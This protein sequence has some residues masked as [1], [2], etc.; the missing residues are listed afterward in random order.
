[1][2]TVDVITTGVPEILLL[3]TEGGVGGRTY[4]PRAK[5]TFFNA[6]T[7]PALGAGDV[8]VVQ[9]NGSL[10]AGFAYQLLDLRVTLTGTTISQLDNFADYCRYQ[11]VLD[12][13]VRK[14]GVLCGLGSYSDGAKAF[15][16]FSPTTQDDMSQY[17][18]YP[19]DKIGDQVLLGGQDGDVVLSV[20]L[21]DDNPTTTACTIF[22]EFDF[23]Q[24]TIEQARKA[25]IYAKLFS[26]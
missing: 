4:L 7:I 11:F 15:E 26:R 13:L 20:T 16:A 22:Y 17:M 2:A 12:G 23:L 25:I 10:P 9:F 19:T 1:M 14:R 21:I 8:S 24:F 3:E 18:L 6:T 5:V